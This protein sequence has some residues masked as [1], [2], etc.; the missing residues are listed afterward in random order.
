MD[1]TLLVSGIGVLAI[2][3]VVI[4]V[5]LLIALV[6]I[7]IKMFLLR[8]RERKRRQWIRNHYRKHGM[9]DR[10]AMCEHVWSIWDVG[11]GGG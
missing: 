9:Y 1:G 4:S 2:L 5:A 8:H 3:G 10:L 11:E 7:G 6:V